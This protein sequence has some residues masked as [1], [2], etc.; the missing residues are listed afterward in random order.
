[1]FIFIRPG[2]HIHKEIIKNIQTIPEPV[3][4]HLLDIP[5]DSI[6]FLPYICM[7]TAD[8]KIVNGWVP[9]QADSLAEDWYLY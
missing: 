1:M 2:D 5:L 3:K 6:E 4:K 8:N 9:S 7:K